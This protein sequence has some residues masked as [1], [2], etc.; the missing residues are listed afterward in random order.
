MSEEE[1]REETIEEVKK[2]KKK[3]KKL[4]KTVKIL[5]WVSVIFGL[6]IIGVIAYFGMCVAVIMDIFSYFG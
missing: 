1:F 4:K 6:S 5:T 3:V 2:L